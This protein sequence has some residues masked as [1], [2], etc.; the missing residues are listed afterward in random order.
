VN[1]RGVK[2]SGRVGGIVTALKD[3]ILLA[4]SAFGIYK[5]ITKPD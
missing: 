4:F 2:E 5:T 1:Y 3:T